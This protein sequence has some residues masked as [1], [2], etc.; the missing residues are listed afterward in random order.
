MFRVDGDSAE[1]NFKHFSV[2]KTMKWYNL[3]YYMKWEYII[4]S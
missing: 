4:T 2:S 1:V 3:F